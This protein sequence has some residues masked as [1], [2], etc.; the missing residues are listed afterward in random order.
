M[1]D[2][3]RLWQKDSPAVDSMSETDVYKILMLYFIW[4]WFPNLPVKFAFTNRTKAV[5]LGDEVDIGLIKEN[6]RHVQQLLFTDAEIANYRSWGMFPETFL[7]DLRTISLPDVLVEKTSGGQLRIEVEG[8]WFHVTLW[9][10]YILPIVSEL[11]VRQFVGEDASD[12]LRFIKE[13]EA[14]LMAKIPMIRQLSE[15]SKISLFDLRRRATGLWERHTSGILLNEVPKHIAG[16]SN[17]QVAYELGVEATGTNAHELPMAISA[18][19]GLESD[20]ALRNAPFE[21]LKKW[22]RIFGHKALIMLPDAYGS[23]AF[24]RSVPDHFLRDYKGSRQDSGDPFAYGEMVIGTYKDHGINPMDKLII[25]SD[26]LTVEKMIELERR[27]I[28]RIL[29]AFGWGTNKGFDF[30]DLFKAL[31]MVMKLV[32]AAGESAV[33]LS[34][35]IEKAIGEL[36]AIERYKHLHRYAITF[37]E[38]PVY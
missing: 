34:D 6:I 8:L 22:Q 19:R 4:R 3:N 7:R 25:F 5:R 30:G 1:A 21:V 36:L 20:E 14:R 10:L 9:E 32:M 12:H 35:N 27:F 26:G 24:F 16:I 33:K 23:E 18:L 29:V 31:S 28:G 17:V 37:R 15:N 11:R 2:F 38:T 13:G